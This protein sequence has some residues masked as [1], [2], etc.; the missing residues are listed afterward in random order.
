MIGWDTIRPG[1]FADELG[2]LSTREYVDPYVIAS[3]YAR[4]G[5][6]IGAFEWLSLARLKSGRSLVVSAPTRASKTSCAA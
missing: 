6:K 2:E 5:E 4:L 3:I 1:K